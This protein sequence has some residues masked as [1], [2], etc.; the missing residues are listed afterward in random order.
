LSV[1]HNPIDDRCIPD[2][3]KL[4]NL[5]YIDLKGTKITLSGIKLMKGLHLKFFVVPD[6]VRPT[7]DPEVV[8]VLPGVTILRSKQTPVSP[9]DLRLFAPLH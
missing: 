1:G 4:A 5:T 9:D 6:S 7:N 3:R 8:K 2:L